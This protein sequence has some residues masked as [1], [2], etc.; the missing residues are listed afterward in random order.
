MATCKSW[1]PFLTSA[2]LGNRQTKIQSWHLS[3]AQSRRELRIGKWQAERESLQRL[4][5]PHGDNTCALH[6]RALASTVLSP[7]ELDIMLRMEV[8]LQLQKVQLVE[9]PCL[10][11]LI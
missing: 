11:E 5:P 8:E 1:A 9:L 3:C 7:K 6:R 10:Q 4:W 2:M